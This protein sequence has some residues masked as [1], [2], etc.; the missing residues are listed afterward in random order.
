MAQLAA[1]E[2]QAREIAGEFL[3][4]VSQNHLAASGV[5]SPAQMGGA[6]P[7]RPTGC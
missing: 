2:S 3:L 7:S 6:K 5:S 1:G 4:E